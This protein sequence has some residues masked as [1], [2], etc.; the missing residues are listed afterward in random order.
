MVDIDLEKGDKIVESLTR[1]L[2]DEWDTE[3]MEFSTIV[4]VTAK[5][6]AGVLLAI[7]KQIKMTDIDDDF[8][9]V[10]KGIKAIMGNNM[11]MEKIKNEREEIIKKIDERE[12]ELQELE[13]KRDEVLLRMSAL[14]DGKLN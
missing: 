2:Y 1:T 3:E 7:E 6:T 5:F 14:G 12:K 11:K 9:K 13:Q 8:V 10:M 4:Y